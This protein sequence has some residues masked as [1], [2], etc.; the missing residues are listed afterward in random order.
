MDNKGV[1][2]KGGFPS[3]HDGGMNKGPYDGGKGGKKGKTSSVFIGGLPLG[4][5]FW[6]GIF[7]RG[8][9]LGGN[10]S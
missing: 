1:M 6:E 9:P 5:N 10:F 8:V 2:S 3:P 4:W 7:L